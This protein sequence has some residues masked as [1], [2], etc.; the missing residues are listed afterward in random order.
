MFKFVIKKLQSVCFALGGFHLNFSIFSLL[1]ACTFMVFIVFTLSLPFYALANEG[2]APP[3]PNP[4]EQFF[5]FILIGLFFYFLLIRPQQKKQKAQSSFLSNLKEGEEILTTGGIY[6]KIVRIMGEYV[7]LEVDKT[8]QIR[9][10]KNAI[11]SYTQ[12]K[13]PEKTP[14]DNKKTKK[15][16]V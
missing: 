11:S 4:L 14:S 16:K 10:L 12:E 3:K 8:T 6:G 9:L 2:A 1:K 5:P 13:K 7:L 15:I